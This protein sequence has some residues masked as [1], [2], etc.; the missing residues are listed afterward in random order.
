VGKKRPNAWGLYDTLGNVEE[1]CSDF[2][3]PDHRGAA[4]AA[5]VS[6][7]R[8]LRGGSW[9][10]VPWLLRAA[11]RYRGYPGLRGDNLGVRFSEVQAVSNVSS[12]RAGRPGERSR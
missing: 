5:P 4:R 8:V 12:G 6:A 1:W 11:Y 3:T 10:D 9:F 2:R 7:G